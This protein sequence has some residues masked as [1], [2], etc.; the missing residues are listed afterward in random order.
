[1]SEAA[2]EWP[3]RQ[4]LR[5]WLRLQAQRGSLGAVSREVDPEFELA[6]ILARLDGRRSVLFERVAGS[7]MRVAGNTVLSRDDLA[8]ALG[9]ATR[10]AP[11]VFDTAR[12]AP[13]ECRLVDAGQA[14][15]LATPAEGDEP[16]AALPI[17]VH[18]ELDA[19]RYISAGVV[20]SRDPRSGATNLSIHR[21]QVTGGGRLRALILPG[22]MRAILDESEQAGRALELA[23]V[24]GVDP[25]VTL[26][27]QARAPRDVDELEVCSALRHTP[28]ELVQ[29]PTV[30]LR[31]PAHAEILIE[32]R[33]RPGERESEG[34]FGEFPRTY[35]PAAPG[36]VLDVISVSHRADPI[37]QTIL[38][39]GVEH[40]LVGGIPRE[41]DLW[42]EL[43]RVN[44]A[45]KAVRM[46][47]GGSC[48]FHA[49]VSLSRPE[50]GRAREALM[51]AFAANPVLKHVVAVDDDVDVFDDKQVEWALATRVQ[52]DRDLVVLPDAQGSTLDPSAPC[53]KTA[54][55]GIDATVGD[56]ERQAFARIRVPGAEAIDIE[57][58]VETAAAGPS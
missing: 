32:A 21:L 34:P 39:S 45:V 3:E 13:R 16:L 36:P 52:A 7:D 9:C 14:P 11:A 17:P 50:R 20:V 18:H 26:A 56:G 30:D 5:S 2:G 35:S 55:L 58:T 6:G 51:A 12:R 41:A 23:I 33:L 42:R 48:R 29:A 53:G 38:S 28:L 8:A 24:I 49:V 22:R 27:T 31:V 37:F 57:S 46:S 1:M 10:D 54:K 40:L 4:D 43:K 44:P 25:L 15:V 47:E 19:G